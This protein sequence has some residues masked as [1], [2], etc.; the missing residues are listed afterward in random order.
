MPINTLKVWPL[1]AEA[2]KPHWGAA[3]RAGDER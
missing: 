3:D 2:H 1:R